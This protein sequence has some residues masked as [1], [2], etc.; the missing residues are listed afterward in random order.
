MA[1]KGETK[2]SRF[3]VSETGRKGAGFGTVEEMQ[4]A[5]RI[6]LH[7]AARGL[8]A[9]GR[10]IK[11]FYKRC[12]GVFIYSNNLRKHPEQR[13]RRIKHYFNIWLVACLPL[14]QPPEKKLYI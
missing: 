8:R 13:A 5:G 3:S 4:W 11:H 10:T 14:R 6:N 7:A 1:E 2:I 12:E 9:E